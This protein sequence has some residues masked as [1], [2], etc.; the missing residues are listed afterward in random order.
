MVPWHGRAGTAPGLHRQIQHYTARVSRVRC[1][2]KPWRCSQQVGQRRRRTN[3][4]HR[5]INHTSSLAKSTIQIRPSSQ[6]P[7][8]TRGTV[9]FVRLTAPT[10]DTEWKIWIKRLTTS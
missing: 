1:P 5:N 2:V 7:T 8:L 3:A 6:P 4:P 10:A 9:K